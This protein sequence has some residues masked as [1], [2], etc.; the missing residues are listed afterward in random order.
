MPDLAP[1]SREHD[2]PGWPYAVSSGILGWILDAFDF[3][4]VIFLVETLAANFHVGKQSIVWTI[5]ISLAMRPV[6]ALVFGALAD[7]I[8]RRL[9]L[10]KFL[11]RW[12]QCGRK[13]LQR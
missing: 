10:D 9:P 11:R 8:G 13:R 2:T 4:V 1:A 6:G 3:F 7:R 5:S 12:R